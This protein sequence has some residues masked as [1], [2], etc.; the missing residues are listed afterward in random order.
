[1]PAAQICPARQLL[2]QNPRQLNA[3]SLQRYMTFSLGF[4]RPARLDTRGQKNGGIT[5]AV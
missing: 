2:G 5:A 4:H 1:M 3:V